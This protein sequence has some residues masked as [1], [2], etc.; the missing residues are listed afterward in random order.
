[1]ATK[2]KARTKEPRP[3]KLRL[4]VKAQIEGEKG[5]DDFARFLK[6]LH[7]NGYKGVVRALVRELVEVAQKHGAIVPAHIMQ[8]VEGGELGATGQNQI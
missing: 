3:L 7:D 2:T 8:F 1:M 6:L 4:T 5:M